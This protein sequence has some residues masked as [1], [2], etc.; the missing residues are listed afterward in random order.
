MDNSIIESFIRKQNIAFVCPDGCVIMLATTL[1]HFDRK[2]RLSAKIS[3]KQLTERMVG[4]ILY[5]K[6]LR[7]TAN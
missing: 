7:I 2:M 1:R 4:G 5:M 6:Y 3:W